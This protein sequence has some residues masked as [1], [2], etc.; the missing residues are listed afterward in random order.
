MYSYLQYAETPAMK[1]ENQIFHL[2]KV[3]RNDM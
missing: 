3:K 2:L 1:Q